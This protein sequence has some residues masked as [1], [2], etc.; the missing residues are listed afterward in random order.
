M[1]DAW[2]GVIGTLLGAVIGGAIS[3]LTTWEL[4][5]RD[6]QDKRRTLATGLL[7]EIRLLVLSLRDIHGTTT[8]ANRVMEPFQTAMYDQAGANLL[9]FTPETVR[10]LNIFYNGVHELRTTL[11]RYRIN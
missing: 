6:D 7:S 10:T 8:A 1:S 11:A 5:R 3:Y 2:I 4:K 9:F